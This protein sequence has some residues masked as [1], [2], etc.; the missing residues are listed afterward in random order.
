MAVVVAGLETQNVGFEVGPTSMHQG[1][2][3]DLGMVDAGD[4]LDIKI[5]FNVP[6]APKRRRGPGKPKIPGGPGGPG[7]PVFLV[8]SGGSLVRRIKSSLKIKPDI[9]KK[10]DFSQA[11]LPSDYEFRGSK[12]RVPP[13]PN[14]PINLK[15]GPV[16][17]S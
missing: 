6:P 8:L 2:R 11:D 10:S 9:L 7:G 17:T 5:V 13:R 4:V 12:Y 1:N 14:T 16:P 15:W 3:Y